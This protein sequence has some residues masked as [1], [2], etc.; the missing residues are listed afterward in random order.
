MSHSESAVNLKMKALKF[1]SA[2]KK[3]SGSEKESKALSFERLK[4]C[5]EFQSKFF[6]QKDAKVIIFDSEVTCI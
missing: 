3:I 4:Q 6:L 1:V 2:E 5:R